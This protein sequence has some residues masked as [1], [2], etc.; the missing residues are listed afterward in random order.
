LITKEKNFRKLPEDKRF[1]SI[2]S[3]NK[4]RNI[5]KGIRMDK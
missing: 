2:T 4:R 3:G 5:N 1:S